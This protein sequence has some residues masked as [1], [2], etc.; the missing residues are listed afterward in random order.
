[1]TG[2]VA[3]LGEEWDTRPPPGQLGLRL[4]PGLKTGSGRNVV[5]P[6]IHRMSSWFGEEQGRWGQ[7]SPAKEGK[8]RGLILK[9]CRGEAC[10]Y[11]RRA[12][13]CIGGL[14]LRTDS[15]VSQREEEH[16]QMLLPGSLKRLLGVPHPST[17]LPLRHLGLT[18]PFES[19]GDV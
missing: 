10:P 14:W 11:V 1:M 4:G 16:L 8:P 2:A 17:I 12:V 19:Q 9:V 18:L 6:H 5:Y 13:L 7:L 15:L 3:V